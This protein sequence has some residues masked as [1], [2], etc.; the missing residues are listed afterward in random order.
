MSTLA[1]LLIWTLAL[2]LLGCDNSANSNGPGSRLYTSET[3]TTTGELQNYFRELCLQADPLAPADGAG[4]QCPDLN[5]LVRT[6]FNDVDVRCDQY[7]AWI[8]RQRIDA[9]SFKSGVSATNTLL[10]G[11]S[12]GGEEALRN[13]AQVLGFATSVYDIRQASL[14]NGLESSTIKKLV[15]ERRLAYRTEFLKVQY[16]NYPDAV[17]ALR[18]YLRICTPQTIVLDANNYALAAASGFPPPSLTDGIREERIAIAAGTAP[19]TPETPVGTVIVRPPLPV[20]EACKGLFPPGA[21]TEAEVRSVQLSLCTAPDGKPGQAT[22]AALRIYRETSGSGGQAEI[23]RAEYSDI[24]QTGCKRDDMMGN[25]FR[26]LNY[27]EVIKFRGKDETLK[28]FISNLNKVVSD[29]GDVPEGVD[30]NLPA[31]RA[32]IATARKNLVLQP[33]LDTQVTKGLFDT[34][35]Q[36]ANP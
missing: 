4:I 19:V 27:F 11:V 16:S 10:S 34:V 18:G 21:Y 33:D 12:L 7:L 30:L 29:G 14:L 25:Q 1:K 32:K 15:H 36:Q 28:L 2:F 26:Y 5:I 22:L 8:D 9:S 24:T 35:T 23:S 6:G 31:L 3:T 20:C 17:Y 13:T